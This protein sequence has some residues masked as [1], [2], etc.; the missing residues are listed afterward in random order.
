VEL[1][2]EVVYLHFELAA[3]VV[4]VVALLLMA[5][6]VEMLQGVA[7]VVAVVLPAVVKP[8]VVLLRAMAALVV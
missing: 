1:A 4:V 7:V 6:L 3:E 2:E 8:A 5:G